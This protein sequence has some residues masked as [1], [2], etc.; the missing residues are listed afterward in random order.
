MHNGKGLM[1]SESN[2]IK[3]ILL[4]NVFLHHQIFFFML[5]LNRWRKPRVPQGKSPGRNLMC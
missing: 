5:F 4:H 2:Y 1:Q 3:I